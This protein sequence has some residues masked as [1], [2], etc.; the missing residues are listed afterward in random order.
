LREYR[1]R[2]AAFGNFKLPATAGMLQRHAFDSARL[3][4]NSPSVAKALLRSLRETRFKD[5]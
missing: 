4:R 3:R 2:N 1:G 5:V